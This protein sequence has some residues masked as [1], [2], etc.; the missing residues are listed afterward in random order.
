MKYSAV[1]SGTVMCGR[2]KGGVSNPRHFFMLDRIS[3]GYYDDPSGQIWEKEVMI[4]PFTFWNFKL[5]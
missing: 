5:A 2:V 4:S 1:A 3:F